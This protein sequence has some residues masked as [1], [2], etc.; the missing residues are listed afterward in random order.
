[1]SVSAPSIC[2]NQ[3]L[4]IDRSILKGYYTN[5]ES[6]L[7]INAGFLAVHFYRNTY[8]SKVR[9]MK[10][11]SI[12]LLFITLLCVQSTQGMRCLAYEEKYSVQRPKKKSNQDNLDRSL[13]WGCK[14]IMDS[15]TSLEFIYSALHCRSVTTHRLKIIESFLKDGANPNTVMPNS[16]LGFTPFHWAISNNSPR[17][18]ALLL[19]YKANPHMAAIK[20]CTL[21]PLG[22]LL[23]NYE[24]IQ[25][26]GY[27]LSTEV[28]GQ[29]EFRS[30]TTR[31]DYPIARRDNLQIG[32]LLLQ[33]HVKASNGAENEYCK[34]LINNT[35]VFRHPHPQCPIGGL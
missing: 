2:E 3:Q 34:G 31:V 24:F 4:F 23:Q 13:V 26:Q 15:P 7:Y 16:K 21:K 35:L 25:K 29:T 18:V 8:E 28:N 27:F 17:L 32:K 33:R 9:D 11:H 10:L 1:M 5:A 19:K 22:I 30:L 14:K 6:G 20:G 12:N